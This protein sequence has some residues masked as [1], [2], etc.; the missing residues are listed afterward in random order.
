MD[1]AVAGSNPV[2]H[3]IFQAN[4]GFTVDLAINLPPAAKI[5]LTSAD[6]HLFDTKFISSFSN[7]TAAG[8][9]NAQF[10][11]SGAKFSFRK[12]VTQAYAG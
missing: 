9:S 5:S 1:L 8:R 10:A 12:R 2:D 7:Q 11:D 4:S 3:P 6:L